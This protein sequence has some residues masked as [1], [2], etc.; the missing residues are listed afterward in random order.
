MNRPVA[1]AVVAAALVVFSQNPGWAQRFSTLQIRAT[2]AADL[3]TWDSYVTQ[4]ERS[5]NLRLRNADRDPALPGRSVERLQQFHRGVPIWGAD[6]VRDSERG[7]TL[8]LFGE[9]SP[10]LTLSTDAALAADAAGARILAGGGADATL[11]RA[12]E[13]VILRQASGEHRLAYVAVLSTPRDV[14]RIFVDANTGAELLR[15]SEIERQSAVGTGR[16]VLGDTKKISTLLVARTFFTDDQ[17]RPPFLATFDMRGNLTR[18]L[19]V[20]VR[21]APLVPSDRASDTDNTWTDVATVDAH[22]HVGWTYDY[23]FK[24]FGRHGLDDRDRPILA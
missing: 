11:V 9:L 19:N 3:R 23:F 15:Y 21:G 2:P 17:L 13:L 22:V 8:S 16:G 10:E 4:Q 12:P 7:V 24:R 18:A 1:G 14:A 20:I 6:L 5:G